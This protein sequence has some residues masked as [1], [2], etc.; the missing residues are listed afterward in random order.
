MTVDLPPQPDGPPIPEAVYPPEEAVAWL[1]TTT[2]GALRKSASLGLIP[3]TRVGRSREIGFSGAD[4]T[5]IAEA[6]FRDVKVSGSPRASG[7]RGRRTTDVMPEL[8]PGVER[9]RPKPQSARRRT[10]RAS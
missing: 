6:G 8:P 4:I 1:R 9:L 10:R 7:R 3:H 5:A 2:P